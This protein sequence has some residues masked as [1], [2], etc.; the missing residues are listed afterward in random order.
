MTMSK[1]HAALFAMTVL[2]VGAQPSACRYVIQEN[3]IL[4]QLRRQHLASGHAG[5]LNDVTPKAAADG[6]ASTADVFT[7]AENQATEQA[8]QIQNLVLQGY[9]AIVINA[10]SLT[11]LNGAIKE[12][13]DA[14]VVVVTFDGIATEPCAWRVTV[15]FKETGYRQVKFLNDVH[16]RETCSKSAAFRAPRS[17]ASTMRA[18]FLPAS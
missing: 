7:T 15:D 10:A 3:R 12:A 16:P 2:H 4:E 5:Q 14:G 6:N 8:A 9:D 17:T 18:S 11:A 1:Y 13:C